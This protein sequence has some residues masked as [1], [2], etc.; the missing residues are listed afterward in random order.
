MQTI[1][2]ANASYYFA[3]S[4]LEGVAGTGPGALPQAVTFHAFAL[5]APL[6]LANQWTRRTL[7]GN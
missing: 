2:Q 5:V 4:A 3:P 7:F 1:T 6:A